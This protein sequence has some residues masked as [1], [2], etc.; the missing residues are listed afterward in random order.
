MT[1]PMLETL[2]TEPVRIHLELSSRRGEADEGR[3]PILRKGG[4]YY[5]APY[6]FVFLRMRFVN[7]SRKPTPR[8][9]SDRL[10]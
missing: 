6:E 2:R 4:T 1:L 10:C 8:W 5:P 9:N 7:L 3:M